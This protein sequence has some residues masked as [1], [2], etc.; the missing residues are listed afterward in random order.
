MDLEKRRQQR[1]EE[2]QKLV[3]RR[4]E[5]KNKV[6][7]KRKKR[8]LFSSKRTTNE[9]VPK[10]IKE[11]SEDIDTFVKDLNKQIKVKEDKYRK[12]LRDKNI[13]SFLKKEKNY[14]EEEDDPFKYVGKILKY[15]VYGL[16][17]LVVI[18]MGKT[19]SSTTR[20]LY[21]A[22]QLNTT[23]VTTAFNMSIWLVLPIMAIIIFLFLQNMMRGFRGAV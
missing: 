19:I 13:D 22:S 6:L 1:L 8:G 18:F 12:K 20:E 14:F 9:E 11:K 2:E 7:E 5:E 4:E 15:L 16:P 23:Q 21:N 10:W 17:F 3:K